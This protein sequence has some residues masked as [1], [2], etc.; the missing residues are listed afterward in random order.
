ML[1]GSH[2]T[3]LHPQHQSSGTQSTQQQ[4]MQLT[5]SSN[6]QQSNSNNITSSQNN[7][8]HGAGSSGNKSLPQM[9]PLSAVTYSHLHSVIG[10]M[11]IYDMADYQH[12]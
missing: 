2:S 8:S 1:H 4:H 12:L 11:P 10:S 9:P 7:S 3:T 6:N 5:L